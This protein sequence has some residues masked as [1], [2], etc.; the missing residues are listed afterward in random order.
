MDD[1]TPD[2]P[3]ALEIADAVWTRPPVF[4]G[5]ATRSGGDKLPLKFW[6]DLDTVAPPD[7]LVRR[8]LGTS[9]LALIYGE[10]GCGKTFLATGLAMHIALGWSWF[11]RLVTPGAVV[12]VACEG[13][14]GIA[15]RLAA[16]RRRH[17]LPDTV[18]IAIVPAAVNLGPGGHDA[19]KVIDAVETVEA[20]TGQVVQMIVVD[21]LARAMGSGDENSTQDM[22]VFI[23]SCD[24]IR[25]ATGATILIVHHCGKSQQSGARGSSALLGAVDTAI[26]VVGREAGRVAKIVKQKDGADGE[27]LG[28]VLEVIEVGIDDEAEPITTCIVQRTD[29]VP[30][31]APKLSPKQKRALDVL[32]N[33][34]ADHPEEPPNRVTFPSAT[35]TK[36]DGFRKALES[37]GV[38]DRNVERVQWARIKES[39]CNKGLLRIKDGYCWIPQRSVTSARCYAAVEA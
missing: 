35:L 38:T 13:T 25:V 37:E 24:R 26:E 8:L 12:Y 7:K 14:A 34:L 15:N 11:G 23:A 27:E 28:F 33:V 10:P 19:Q 9:T 18:P 21:T 1:L 39:L 32:R 16:Y 4:K 6:G 30:K 2:R 17:E 20:M 36:V 5:H 22:G 29:E 3:S 31:A